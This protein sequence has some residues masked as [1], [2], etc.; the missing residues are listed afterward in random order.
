MIK[1]NKVQIYS[2]FIAILGSFPIPAQ[3]Y[4]KVLYGYVALHMDMCHTVIRHYIYCNLLWKLT[5]HYSNY[6]VKYL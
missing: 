1:I 3:I 4:M 5:M 6:L 2:L